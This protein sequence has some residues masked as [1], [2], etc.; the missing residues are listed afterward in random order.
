[1]RGGGATHGRSDLDCGDSTE[2]ERCAAHRVVSERALRRVGWAVGG[3]AGTLL[4]VAAVTAFRLGGPPGLSGLMTPAQRQLVE[5]RTRMAELRDTIAS[6][7]KRNEQIRLLA[8]LPGPDSAAAQS[9][10]P[11]DV[12]TLIVRAN[13]L[14]ASFAQCLHVAHEEQRAAVGDAIDHADCGV[15]LE[16]VL[17][18]QIPPHFAPLPASRRHRCG[19]AIWRAGRGAGG[20]GR[21]GSADRPATAW[22]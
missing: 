11:L 17:A 18:R 21:H 16:S 1:M 9:Q 12:D 20:R 5:L 4:L 13:T 22:Y 7:D 14:S 8:G 6:I 15:A 3:V 19:R 10:I 2:R